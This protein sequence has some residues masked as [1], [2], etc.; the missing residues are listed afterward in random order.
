MADLPHK[1]CWRAEDARDVLTTEALEGTESFFLATHFP[2]SDFDVAGSHAGDVASHDEQGLLDALSSPDVRHAFCV[3]EGEP[4]SGKSHLIRWLRIRW[5]AENDNVLLIQRLDGSLEGTL[6]QL[7]AAIPDHGELFEGFAARVHNLTAQGQANEFFSNLVLALKRGHLTNPPPDQAWCDKFDLHRLLHPAEV[8]DRWRAPHRIVE[9]L[10]GRKGES[11]R[12]QDLARFNLDDIVALEEVLRPLKAPSFRAAQFTRE[13]QKESQGIQSLSDNIRTN[14]TQQ[15]TLRQRFSHSF[16]L[17]GA[18]NERRNNAVQNVLGISTEGLKDMFGRL[19]RALAPRR[20]V[21]LL[22]DITAWEGVDNQLIDVLVTNVDSRDTDDLC[23][24]VSVV[25]LTPAYFNDGKFQANYRQRVTHHVLLGHAD[26]IGE[27]QEVSSLK[28]ESAQ[29][30]FAMSYLRAVRAGSERLKSWA[31]GPDPVPNVCE[32]CPHKEPCHVAFGEEDSVGLYPF[33][34]RAITQLFEALTDPRHQSTYRTP[35]GMLQGVLGPTLNSPAT[36]EGS[37]YP[38]AAIL[39]SWLPEELQRVSTFTAEVIKARCKDDDE[40]GFQRLKRL[41]RF[42]GTGDVEAPVTSKDSSGELSFGAVPR[43]IFESFNLPWIGEDQFDDRP[44]MPEPERTKPGTKESD[45][46]PNGPKPSDSKRGGSEGQKGPAGGR[47]PRREIKSPALVDLLRYLARWKEGESSRTAELNR[48]AFQLVNGLPWNRLGI[49]RW[50]RKRLFTQ[51]TVM[52]AG[53]KQKRA[54]HFVLP[55]EDWLVRGIE[56]FLNLRFSGDVLDP[57]EQERHRHTY[58]ATLL[59]L[60]GCVKA[61]V[62][63]RLPALPDG[64]DWA[65]AGTATK[66]LVARAW[67]R[68]VVPPTDPPWMQWQTVLNE[69]EDVASNPQDR[70]DSWNRIVEKTGG[71]HGKH[72][73]LLRQLVNLPQGDSDSLDF[74]DASVG[75]KA[76]LELSRSFHLDEFPNNIGNLG[77]Q[78]AELDLLIR[79]A[80][81]TEQRLSKVPSRE[82]ERLERLADDVNG[83]LRGLSVRDHL[84]RVDKIVRSVSNELPHASPVAVREWSNKVAELRDFGFLDEGP[85]PAGRDVEVFIDEILCPETPRPEDL[86]ELLDWLLRAPVRS[87][88]VLSNSLRVAERT[89]SE[90]H[91]YVAGFLNERPTAS[92][93]FDAIQETGRRIVAASNAALSGLGANTDE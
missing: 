49:P 85:E 67:L 47:K 76:I 39:S 82:F 4:G 86:A 42:W 79:V 29:V 93:S 10:S 6:R 2:I 66:V 9:L 31:G 28:T 40:F 53:T 71:S 26:S 50:I 8:R 14:P 61:H 30:Q 81:E 80:N 52:L 68:G 75:A 64:G 13:L 41:I 72:R 88:N 17:V 7:Q 48:A 62:R 70:V 44:T 22:E 36:I 60:E 45:D 57:R 65:V 23:P 12:D 74:A 56:G 78:F 5:P 55:N 1:A 51:D 90:L 54:F 91:R 3:V 16:G 33:N 63:H 32:T 11:E 27:F 19:R 20:L 59:E 58:G 46:A 92:G 73:M 87:M 21:L 37:D 18:L 25:G 43:G 15:E 77:A 34:R 89:V 84:V 35:R 38:N 24:M 69:E 83:S